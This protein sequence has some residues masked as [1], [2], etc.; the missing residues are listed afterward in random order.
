VFLPVYS[1]LL[2]I[3]ACVFI[4][5]GGISF[6]TES[7]VESSCRIADILIAKTPSITALA[8]SLSIRR[9]VLRTYTCTEFLSR[10]EANHQ[11]I[12]LH[13]WLYMLDSPSLNKDEHMAN[14]ST[15]TSHYEVLHYCD[16]TQVLR[17]AYFL[18]TAKLSSILGAFQTFL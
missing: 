18:F 16:G 4:G 12:S 7:S 6:G 11:I 5:A 9:I 8:F 3:G 17:I 15:R 1:S 10:L 13:Q 14:D 2:D